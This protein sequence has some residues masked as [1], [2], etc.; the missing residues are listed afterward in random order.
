[1]QEH[2][3]SLFLRL[4]PGC[5][6]SPFL[7]SFF[8]SFIWW[9]DES[10]TLH[11]VVWKVISYIYDILLW[12]GAKVNGQ[13]NI[14][15]NGWMGLYVNQ[16]KSID[17]KRYLKNHH[18]IHIDKLS[19]VAFNQNCFFHSN[20]SSVDRSWIQFYTSWIL[21]GTIS[22]CTIYLYRKRFTCKRRVW[23]QKTERHNS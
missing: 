2:D 15:I 10:S 5:S 23:T 21:F 1:M 4:R 11:C 19:C 16:R 20:C 18:Q 14:L 12:F 9:C 13:K 8:S 22:V 3:L 6:D 7:F 17:K